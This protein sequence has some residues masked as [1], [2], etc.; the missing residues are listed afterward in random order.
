MS[1]DKKKVKAEE[2]KK[3]LEE[4]GMLTFRRAKLQAELN[5]NA[6]RSNE[7]GAELEKAENG[8]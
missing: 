3:L 7:I 5:K 4:L 8:K 2:D 6:Q 1:E